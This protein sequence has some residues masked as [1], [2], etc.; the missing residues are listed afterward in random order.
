MTPL[1]AI[2]SSI[3][4]AIISSTGTA[5]LGNMKLN[6]RLSEVELKVAEKYVSKEDL[7]LSMNKFEEHLIRI[8]NKFDQLILN[9]GNGKESIRG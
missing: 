6:S 8:E 3:C 2:L 9:T 5:L 7:N 4:A 1:E